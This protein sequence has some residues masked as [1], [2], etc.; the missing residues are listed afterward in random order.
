MK[1]YKDFDAFI[2]EKEKQT[3]TLHILGRD[4]EV[5]LELPWWYVV[6]VDRMRIGGEP[7][8]GEENIEMLK[9]LLKPEDYEYVVN[10]KDFKASYFWQIIAYGWLMEEPKKKK[11]GG[12]FKTEDDVRVEK[13]KDESAKKSQSAP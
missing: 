6:K 13:S 1:E 10:H 3:K 9:Y 8:S 7:I 11:K 4:C 2:A 12:G 5:P